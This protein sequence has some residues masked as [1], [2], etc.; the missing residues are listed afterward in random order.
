MAGGSSSVVLPDCCGEARA[1]VVPD[2]GEAGAEYEGEALD[3]PVD[4]C[5]IPH[6]LWVMTKTM[7]FKQL[8]CVFSE[9]YLS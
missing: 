6:E 1:V 2:C 5:S 3:L 7:K 4:L 9:G 8:K